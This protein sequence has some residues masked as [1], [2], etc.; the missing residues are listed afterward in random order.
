[1][2]LLAAIPPAFAH[3]PHA[4][5]PALAEAPSFQDTGEIWLIHDPGGPSQLLRSDDFGQHWD[6]A[7]GAPQAD[8][9]VDLAW[10]GDTLLALSTDGTL[11]STTDDGASWSSLE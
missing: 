10:L 8:P 11:W 6:R 4:V 5:I 7:G 2:L 9:L 1:M 3:R